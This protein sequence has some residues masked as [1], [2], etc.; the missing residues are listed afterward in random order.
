[1]AYTNGIFYLDF[2]LGSDSARATQVGTVFSNPS[3]D[4]VM[5]TYA[6]HNHIDG[7][8]ISVTGCTQAYANTYW[9]VTRID[10]DTYTLDGAS[11][12]LFTGAD[13]TGNV[14]PQGGS[15]WLDAWKTFAAGATAARTQPGDTIRIAKS[16]DPAT[17]GINATFTNDSATITLDSALNLT[18][19]TCETA[20][21][22]SA[23]CSSGTDT[24]NFK[25]GTKAVTF[26]IGGAFATGKA[27]YRAIGSSLNLSGYTKFSFWLKAVTAL[28]ANYIRVDLCSDTAGATPVHSFTIDIALVSGRWYPFVCDTGGAMYNGVQ[29]VAIFV[30]VDVGAGGFSAIIDNI[31]ACNDL[32]LTSV[33]GKNTAGETYWTIKSISGTT[34]I[35]GESQQIGAGITEYYG[36]TENTPIYTRGLVKS[37]PA[38][39]GANQVIY[40]I[41]E[42]GDAVN[43]MISY[44]GGWDRTTNIRDGETWLDGTMGQG[45]AISNNNKLYLHLSYMG[46]V[47]Y[48]T[49]FSFTG[50]TGSTFNNLHASGNAGSSH[51]LTSAVAADYLWSVQ[52]MGIAMS[53]QLAISDLVHSNIVSLSNINGTSFS[54]GPNCRLTDFVSCGNKNG[55]YSA[56]Y[57]SNNL[58][59][60]RIGYN[61]FTFIS[62]SPHSPSTMHFYNIIHDGDDAIGMTLL[63]Y[64]TYCAFDRIGK[65]ANRYKRFYLNGEVS[66]QITGGQN[67]AWAHGGSGYCIYFNP[68]STTLPIQYVFHIPVTALTDFALKFYVKKTSSGADC[69]MK[70][71]IFDT[72]GDYLLNADTVDLTDDWVQYSSGLLTPTDSGFCKVVLSAYDGATTGDIGVDTIT[73]EPVTTVDYGLCEIGVSGSPAPGIIFNN[74]IE[75]GGGETSHTFIGG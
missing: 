68:T 14:V 58:Y 21:S 16:T 36:A 63:G 27:V 32:D 23:S 37:I 31:I 46:G 18:I 2:T 57:G 29:S 54:I 10:A 30:L 75:G 74:D 66:D 40:A 55:I 48:N 11:W 61:Q 42:G 15:S 9:K 8:I 56:T 17:L 47:R 64:D 44:I 35:L 4:I 5:G 50:C 33:I 38:T 39:S 28:A 26:A 67:A 1:M 70:C 6:V 20:W 71:T 22:F 60:G 49:P 51:I 41:Q 13:V 43:N 62:N 53:I 45:I 24:T 12:A 52:N 3:G 19:E 72:T 7:S 34:V 25:E 69:S 73:V 65:V 59:N